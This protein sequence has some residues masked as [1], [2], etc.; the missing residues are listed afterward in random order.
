[1]GLSLYREKEIKPVSEKSQNVRAG[2]ALRDHSIQ[3]LFY[4]WGGWGKKAERRGRTCLG[5]MASRN[6]M[7]LNRLPA[8]SMWLFPCL[9]VADVLGG[10]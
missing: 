6:G 5:H 7:E 9:P 1:M 2:K 4:T 10:P 3:A 8:A